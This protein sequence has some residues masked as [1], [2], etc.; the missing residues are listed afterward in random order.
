[1]TEITLARPNTMGL[2]VTRKRRFGGAWFIL[3]LGPAYQR[4]RKFFRLG[5]A[6][7]RTEV[8]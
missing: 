6:E 1:M 2:V 8:D 7:D 3:K 5:V 4:L